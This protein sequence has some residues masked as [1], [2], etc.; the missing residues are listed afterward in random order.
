MAFR[1]RLN[2]ELPEESGTPPGWQPSY[3]L[4]GGADRVAPGHAGKMR[5]LALKSLNAYPWLPQTARRRVEQRL[6]GPLDDLRL[7]FEDG[8]GPRPDAEEDAHAMRAGRTLSELSECRRLGVRLKPITRRWAERAQRTLEL[9][10][11]PLE[12]WPEGFCITLPKLEDP[13]QVHWIL[14][15]LNELE[16]DRGPLPLELMVE[17]PAGLRRL[18]ELLEAAGPRCRGVHF[19]PYDFLA[20]CG[21]WQAELHHPVNGSARRRLLF[22]LSG[23]CELADGP[24]SELP[25]PRGATSAEQIRSVVA[26]WETHKADVLRSRSEG[27]PQSWLLHPAQLVSHAAALSSEAAAAVEPALARLETFWKQ[28]GQAVATGASFDDRAT[29]RL[30]TGRLEQAV[31]EGWI[32]EADVQARLPPGWRRL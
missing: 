6:A 21:I 14:A 23:R 9:V 26:G 24:T 25:L 28:H 7:D 12:R 19:G 31:D 22:E 29:A 3:V 10:L 18:P 17:S 2:A 8:Y 15:L 16:G 11:L 1:Q 27:Y 32:S 20:A 13:A 30:W 5:E 4:Y